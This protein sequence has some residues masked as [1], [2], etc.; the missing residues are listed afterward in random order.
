MGRTIVFDVSETLLDPSALDPHFTRAFGDSSV[1]EQ[2]LEQ[3]IQS[4]L[5]STILGQYMNFGSVAGMALDMLTLRHG[6]ELSDQ[7]R[8][9]IVDGMA[10]LPAH[11]EVPAAL[12]SLRDAGLRLAALTNATQKLAETQ[13]TGAGLDGYFDAVLSVE[14]VRRFKPA[15]EVYEMAAERLGEPGDRLRLVAAHDWDVAGALNAGWRAAFVARPGKIIAPQARSPDI[16]GGDM[17]EVAEQIL[18]VDQ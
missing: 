6:I 1:R 17:T 5:V 7:D 11:G 2:W 13:L 12:Q 9:A 15:V 8:E 18:Q 3:M 14:T 16:L 10:S 4:A